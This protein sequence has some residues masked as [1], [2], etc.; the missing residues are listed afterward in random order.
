[1]SRDDLILHK[2]KTHHVE[3]PN[4]KSYEPREPR[5]SCCEAIDTKDFL[6]DD[7]AYLFALRRDKT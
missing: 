4:I 3:Y 1:M 7:A 5:E 6:D 2:I